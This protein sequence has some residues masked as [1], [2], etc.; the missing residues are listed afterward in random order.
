MRLDVPVR[1]LHSLGDSPV[2]QSVVIRQIL[3]DGLRSDCERVGVREG[4]AFRLDEG[5]HSHLLLETRDGRTAKVRREWARFIEVESVG[6][7]QWPSED[8]KGGS[9]DLPERTAPPVLRESPA[10]RG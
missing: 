10:T 4:Q 5:T 6:G 1:P 3:F 9:G 7:P 8:P 2:G